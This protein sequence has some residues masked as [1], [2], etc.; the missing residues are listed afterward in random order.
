MQNESQQN[1][2]IHKQ[3]HGMPTQDFIHR[4]LIII[5]IILAISIVGL[6]LWYGANVLMLVFAGL[7]LALFLR[8]ISDWVA[9]HT[10]LSVGWS[11]LVVIVGLVGIVALSGWLLAPQ[12]T[13]Q[14]NQLR[15]DLPASV[16]QARQYL[17][18]FPFAEQIMAQVPQSSEIMSGQA[19]MLSRVTGV[20][21]AT[22]NILFNL[23]IIVFVAL[24]FAASPQLYL[25]GLVRLVPLDKRDRFREVLGTLGYTLRWWLIGR[26]FSM[27]V[28]GVITA[29]GLWLL[30]VPLALT[31]GI[32]AALLTFIPNFGP[33]ISAIP[34]TLIALTQSPTQALYVVALYAGSQL[35]ESYLLTPMVQHQAI[36]MPPV[37]IIVAQVFL[38]VVLGL[39]GL[40]LATPLTAAVMVLIKMVYVEDVL[41]DVSVEVKGEKESQQ[42][43]KGIAPQAPAEH[44][45]T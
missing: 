40:I 29:L 18:Q 1:N 27:S 38:G 2:V 30:G 16:Q 39:W 35:I 3:R 43:A 32:L 5:A 12:V 25:S 28:I 9:E 13:R 14:V 33:V 21:S 20:V 37:L 7:L 6:V 10:P 42:E 45:E 26:L 8:G 17:M 31:F 19:N 24:Y 23:F 22:F 11:L 15:E 34:P 41:G 44:A 36:E 4:V